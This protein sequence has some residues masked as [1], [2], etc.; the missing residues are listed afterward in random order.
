MMKDAYQLSKR[1]QCVMDL[2]WEK[3]IAM[4]SLDILENL[5]DIMKNP[6]YV[7]RT[8]NQLLDVNLIQECGSVRYNTQYARKF[9]PCMTR[10]EY[11][12][13]YLVSHGIRKETFGKTVLALLKETQ[14][15][16]NK[17]TDDVQMDEMIAQL[18]EII[19]EIKGQ[20][21]KRE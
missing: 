1:E 18:Q 20:I 4:T 19:D 9:V 17:H 3:G 10:E 13:K 14:D 5:S 8:I 15:N 21:D 2:L 12:A 11:S 6:T 7:H 16:K